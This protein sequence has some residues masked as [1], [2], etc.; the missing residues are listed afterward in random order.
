MSSEADLI[1][2]E[3]DKI[4]VAFSSHQAIYNEVPYYAFNMNAGASA[5]TAVR[6][7]CGSTNNSAIVSD[8]FPHCSAVPVGDCPPGY[9][10][11]PDG[12]TCYKP[13]NFNAGDS[14]RLIT[15]RT[16]YINLTVA[17]NWN[18]AALLIDST[19]VVRAETA[20]NWWL[21][22]PYAGD[23]KQ[24]CPGRLRNRGVWIDDT[25]IAG[26]RLTFRACVEIDS[27]KVYYVGYTASRNIEV[28]IDGILLDNVPTSGGGYRNS[29]EY[30]HMKARRLTVGKHL[31]EVSTEAANTPTV[32]S[33]MVVEIFG[34]TFEEILNATQDISPYWT[35]R[36]LVGSDK[37]Y[38]MI[39]STAGG[40]PIRR[41]YN[42]GGTSPDMCALSNECST[43]PMSRVI[44][45]YLTGH[46]G[47]WLPYVEFAY[48]TERKS[49][50]DFPKDGLRKAGQYEAFMPFWQYNNA[51]QRWVPVTSVFWFPYDPNYK[52]QWGTL[53]NWV[54]ART[55]TSY[56]RYSHELENRN[57]LGQFSGVQYGFKGVL[58]VIVGSNSQSRELY[59]DGFEDYKF[60]NRCAP[61]VA[62]LGDDFDVRKI[63]GAATSTWL[64]DS[65]AHTGKYSLRITPSSPVNLKAQAYNFT[66]APGSYIETN[67]EGE[68]TRK[69]QPWLNLYGFN[70]QSDS[71][72]LLSVWVRDNAPNDTSYPL[73]ISLDGKNVTGVF[74]AK[75]EQWKLLEFRLDMKKVTAQSPTQFP[76]T[77]SATADI[78]IDDIR[79]FPERGQAVT[80]AYDESTMRLMAEL[81]ANNFATLYE[82]DEQGGLIRL[83]KETEKGIITIKETRSSYIKKN[84]NE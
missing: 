6:Y 32:P 83:K 12:L 45:P 66:H 62:C 82:Y 30:Y 47:N 69:P 18:K 5:N 35:I 34:Q 80:Y 73:R 64:A 58:P 79:I 50:E 1:A 46:L 61:F 81:D 68:Y 21:G 71:T 48:L 4:R 65:T 33:A 59:Y 20:S 70:P 57:A 72:Y 11:T 43:I 13:L 10:Q 2:G 40:S 39:V 75:V 16:N 38:D 27:N 56:D 55:I 44:N 49:R 19:G 7:Y 54:A 26:Q 51:M 84:P 3:K 24:G 76:L 41:R 78:F 60:T 37:P 36:N 53:Y 17:E 28:K 29:S 23:Y 8:P 77:L 15:D 42:C 74:K 25:L 22:Y 31:L 63:V 52:W 9:L 67:S 14:M